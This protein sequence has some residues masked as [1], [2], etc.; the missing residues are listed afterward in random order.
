MIMGQEEKAL[1]WKPNNLLTGLGTLAG[2]LMVLNLNFL[3]CC[4]KMLDPAMD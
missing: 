2:D 3:F 1:C 4:M